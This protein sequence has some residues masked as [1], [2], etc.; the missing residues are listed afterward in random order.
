LSGHRSPTAR[1]LESR[2][3]ILG[4]LWLHSDPTIAAEQLRREHGDEDAI[5][6]VRALLVSLTPARRVA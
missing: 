1:Y 4:G 2:E 5:A 3:R 6:W